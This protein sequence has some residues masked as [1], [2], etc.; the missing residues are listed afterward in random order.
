LNHAQRGLDAVY[1]HHD[2]RD[3][4]RHALDAWADR[5]GIILKG[6]PGDKVVKIHG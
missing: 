1:N 3:E 4:K 6:D 5:V 2:Y